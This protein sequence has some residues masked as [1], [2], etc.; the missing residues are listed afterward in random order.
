[1]KTILT[2][3]LLLFTLLT[4]AQKKKRP[5]PLEIKSFRMPKFPVADFPKKS[6]AISEIRVLHVLR[7]SIRMGYS[8]KGPEG[9]IVIL[10]TEKPPTVFLQK[11]IDKMYKNDLD[12]GG[13]KILWV[14]RELRVG[15]RSAF[16]EY[17]YTRFS[18]DAYISADGA[19]YR[20]ACSIDTVFVTESGAD[21]SN[22]HGEDIENAFKLLLKRTLKSGKEILAQDS[23][24]LS[25]QQIMK[26]SE[27]QTDFPIMNA[28]VYKDGAYAT[29]E[30]FLQ[31]KP[32][33]TQL[34]IL[35]LVKNNM[36]FLS[37]DSTGA[38]DTVTIW[39]LCK[40]G[41]LYKYN[42]RRLL[43]IERYGKGFI[44]SN[45]IEE[46]NRR[47]SNMFLTGLAGAFAGG[48]IGAAGAAMMNGAGSD[49]IP[50]VTT[51]PYISKSKKQPEASCIDMATGELSF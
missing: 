1:M 11:H 13:A 40:N 31:N 5:E 47:N 29:F 33:Y 20:K 28:E 25:V 48:L 3:I 46:A 38:M 44:L 30:D 51:F 45:Y 35:S 50:L 24:G 6:M 32:S 9:R 18:T 42:E 36:T 17:A 21:L 41:E 43:P 12:E 34:R 22:W 39:G 19:L 23:S 16:M 26:Q 15:E 4:I 27:P 10:V 8:M 7:D 37:P 14:V 2:A 49:K